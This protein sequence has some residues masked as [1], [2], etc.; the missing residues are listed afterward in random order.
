MLTIGSMRLVFLGNGG[1]RVHELVLDIES[2]L[3]SKDFFFHPFA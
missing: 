1:I 3:S 2:L